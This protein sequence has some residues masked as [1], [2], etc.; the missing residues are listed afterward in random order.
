[1]AR[2]RSRDR[3]RS[4]S[5]S[6]STISSRATSVCAFVAGS[7]FVVGRSLPTLHCG[8]SVVRSGQRLCAPCVWSTG[9]LAWLHFTA[10]MPAS[11]ASPTSQGNLRSVRPHSL[12]ILELALLRPQCTALLH[13][14][15]PSV[16]AAPRDKR[17]KTSCGP[18][19]TAHADHLPSAWALASAQTVLH[20]LCAAIDGT[21]PD[22]SPAPTSEPRAA[23]VVRLLS[24]MLKQA[25]RKATACSADGTCTCSERFAAGGTDAVAS[26]SAA[27]RSR[28]A[29]GA[30]VASEVGECPAASWVRCEPVRSSAVYLAAGA[31]RHC[32]AAPAG[33]G[34]VRCLAR[35]RSSLTHRDRR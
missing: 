24:S 28:E 20:E 22:G 29:V 14:P 2:G 9:S 21:A 13:D 3:E 35:A 26:T 30:A 19:A 12:Q 5:A 25:L 1:M 33:D 15:T 31:Q 23:A 6:R 17:P 4:C 8:Q 27:Q 18:G 11:N 32:T 16:A 34:A 7:G 10:D